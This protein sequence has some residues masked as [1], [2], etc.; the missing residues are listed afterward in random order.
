MDPFLQRGS[1]APPIVF[2][3]L[4]RPLQKTQGAGHPAGFF[5]DFGYRLDLG[6]FCFGGLFAGGYGFVAFFL[7]ICFFVFFFFVIFAAPGVFA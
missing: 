5:R 7:F 3:D 1:V 2:C 4:S 6:D